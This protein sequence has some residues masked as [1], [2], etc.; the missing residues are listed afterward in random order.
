MSND[1][2]DKNRIKDADTLSNENNVGI[3]VSNNE[4][5]K[6]VG[7]GDSNI[8]EGIVGNQNGTN[9]V[10]NGNSSVDNGYGNSVKREE[11]FK[12]LETHKG[13]KV[14]AVIKGHPDPDSIAASLAFK[15]LASHYK[16]QTD[17]VYF[18]KISHQE[19]KALVKT[20]EIELIQ[21]SSNFDFGKYDFFVFND[22]PTT[23]LPIE[24]DKEIKTLVLVDHHKNSGLVKAEFSDIRENVG[25]TC[26][27]Y[28]EYVKWKYPFQVGTK[29]HIKLS[30]AMLYGIRTDTNNLILAREDDLLATAYLS[31]FA[32]RELLTVISEQSI[33]SKSMDILQ[34]ALQNKQI[35]GNFL[36]AGV[37]Y[38][39]DEDRDGIAQAADYLLKRE[40]IDTVIVYGIVGGIAID[41]SLRTISRTLDP[42]K[43]LKELFGKDS[44]GQFYGGGRYDKGGFQV[45]LGI[46]QHCKD[47]E[48]M[49]EVVKSTIL[50]RIFE[51]IGVETDIKKN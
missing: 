19:N 13:C 4:S 27:I 47:K 42:D 33:S 6:N 39:R 11:F 29:S 51:V 22:T 41:G 14:L 40:G 17:I 25:A 23:A 16:I 30:T 28:A 21:Y 38:V 10:S 43:F 18:D 24:L 15:Y 34:F 50:S 49:W 46:F 12:I 5:I 31:T 48:M 26:T 7:N 2:E 36:I 44:K 35:S 45:P 8:G 32:D 1:I 20:L 3:L 37:E 9:I